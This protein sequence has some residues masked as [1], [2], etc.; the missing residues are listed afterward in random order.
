MRNLEKTMANYK[1]NCK[2]LISNGYC[3]LIKVG[4]GCEGCEEYE[5]FYCKYTAVL[6]LVLNASALTFST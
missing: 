6:D 3:S 5:V 4:I 1:T 2:R